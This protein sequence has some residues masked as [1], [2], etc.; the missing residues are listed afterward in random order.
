M[1]AFLDLI[2]E[3]YGGPAQYVKTHCD[4]SDDDVEVIRHNLLIEPKSKL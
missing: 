2:R 1:I 4:L 3:R